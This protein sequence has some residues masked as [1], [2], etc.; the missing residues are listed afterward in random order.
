LTPHI[1]SSTTETRN[2]MKALAV[3]NL[4]SILAGILPK[5]AV[6]R[7]VWPNFVARMDK[8]IVRDEDEETANQHQLSMPWS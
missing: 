8:E 6:N 5:N 2:A 4:I 3:E 1:G 7:A